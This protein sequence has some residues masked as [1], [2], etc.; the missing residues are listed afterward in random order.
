MPKASRFE[1]QQ[2]VLLA[3]A[4]LQQAL[5]TAVA[6]TLL[7]ARCGVSRRQAYRYLAVARRGPLA[8]LPGA[9]QVFTIKLPPELIT[10]VR[11]AARPPGRSLS[12]WV[13]DLLHRAIAL[14][15]AHG[16]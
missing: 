13:A 7:V 15:D 2:R 4:L 11:T 12:A 5:P 8:P 10:Q 9:T 1:H 16:E 14:R 3:Q 6:V